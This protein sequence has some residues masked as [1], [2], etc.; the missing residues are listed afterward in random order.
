MEVAIVLTLVQLGDLH[1]IVCWALEQIDAYGL[2]G[3]LAP[4]TPL[5]YI[6]SWQLRSFGDTD[7]VCIRAIKAIRAPHDRVC[8]ANNHCGGI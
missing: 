1:Q 3:S 6:W 2:L 4:F 8:V 5:P 7:R